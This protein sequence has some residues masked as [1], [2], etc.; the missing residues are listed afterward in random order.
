MD[1]PQTPAMLGWAIFPFTGK[2]LIKPVAPPVLPEQASS[3][4]VLP[5]RRGVW[6][7]QAGLRP[8]PGGA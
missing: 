6:E 5:K 3:C 7:G 4:C 8:S 2:I 1:E